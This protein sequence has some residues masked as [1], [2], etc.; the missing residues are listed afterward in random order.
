MSSP[1]ALRRRRSQRQAKSRYLIVCEG[2][3]TEPEYV[4]FMA[5]HWKNP[6][7]LDI[8]HEYTS[9]KQIVEHA[10]GLKKLAKRLARNDPNEAYEEVW[11]VFDRDEHLLVSEALQQAEANE[12]RIAFSNPNFELWLLLHFRDYNR[13]SPRQEI[14]R[15]CQQYMPGYDKSPDMPLLEQ[16]Y[17]DAVFRAEQLYERQQRDGRS[18]ENPWTEAH[19][20]L[21]SIAARS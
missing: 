10:A 20:L 9:P 1:N 7:V 2:E 18:R 15:L 11:V 13:D 12:I 4:T 3:I 5:R 16:N 6:V 17:P 19:L 14:R 21:K 8:R